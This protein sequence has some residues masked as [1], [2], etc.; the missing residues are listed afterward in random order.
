L[1]VIVREFAEM[2]GLKEDEP[3]GKAKKIMSTLKD[4]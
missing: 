4:E 2:K 1:K 3:T